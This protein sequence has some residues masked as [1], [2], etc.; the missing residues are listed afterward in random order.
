MPETLS[1]PAA[2]KALS[3][4]LSLECRQGFRNRSVRGGLDRYVQDRADA[5]L[6]RVPPESSAW[7]DLRDLLSGLRGEFGQYLA[8]TPGERRRLV[9]TARE[10]LGA[11]A[12]RLE[13]ASGGKAGGLLEE[14]LEPRVP[15]A[16]RRAFRLT[17]LTTVRDLLFFPPKWVVD[18]SRLTPLARAA[19]APG[20]V[21]LLARLQGVSESRRGKRILLRAGLE[22]GT[23]HAGWVW[24]NRPY[25]RQ[26]LVPGRWVLVH[27]A[28]EGGRFG[29]RILGETGSYEFLEADEAETLRRG[30]SVGVFYPTTPTLTQ[31]FWRELIGGVLEAALGEVEDFQPP[32][33]REGGMSLA[34]ALRSVHRPPDTAAFEAARRRMAFDELFH[35]Q[36]FLR[37]RRRSL[38]RY[39][40]GRRYRFDGERVLRFRKSIPFALTGAQKRVLREV[41]EDLARPWPMNRLLQGD[42]GSG[43]TIVAGIAFLYAADSGV[44]GAMLAPTEILARQ[45]YATLRG[46]LEPVGLRTVLLTGDQSARERRE[47]RRALAEGVADV[48]VGTHALLEKETVFRNL[49]LVVIDERHKFGVL[50]RA[51]LEAKGPRPDA[52]MMTAT[53]FPRALVLTEYG[54]TDL[55]VLD[56]KPAGRKPVRTFWLP[57]ARREEA[58]RLVRERALAGERAYLVYPVLQ[59]SRASLKSAVE[60]Y[61]KLRA[62]PF[63]GFR[64]G[65]LHGRMKRE[66]KSEVMEAFRRGDIQ[67]LV[68]TTVVEV[69]L[70]VPEATVAVVEHADRFGLAQLHQIRGR[71]GRGDRPAI[72]VLVASPTVTQ[73]GAARL[74]TLSEVGD[75][76]RL[77]EEDLRQRGPGEIT[78]VSQ[79]GDVSRGFLDLSRDGDLVE[80]ARAEAEAVL[81][82]DPDLS[83]PDHAALCR[84]FYRRY[85]EEMGLASV[86]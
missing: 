18:A 1:V 86:S 46:L 73:E 33:R 83:S 77:A 56:E 63:H 64:V 54:D 60:M 69:G 66:E 75:G 79:S 19:K 36:L 59:E 42:V 16:K 3:A 81:S 50:Q 80:R 82:E 65:L 34:E 5:L 43:K 17:G 15:A 40:K 62:G 6:A 29:R 55:S 51:R 49:G 10:R 14:P 32:G 25:L 31:A 61:R 48:G 52:L 72:C 53:P 84:E 70:D 23:G 85:R 47:A 76:F 74:K 58:Y 68:A 11:F 4:P 20:K 26:E 37:R 27:G 78:G 30:G 24:F 13:Q 22:D 71:I 57:D 8:L 44:Q 45:H 67:I 9:E 12:A 39:E 7:A 2:L 35:L 38:E 21:F 41:R 28:V